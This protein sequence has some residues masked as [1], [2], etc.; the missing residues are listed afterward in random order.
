MQSRYLLILLISFIYISKSN[1]QIYISELVNNEVIFCPNNMTENEIIVASFYIELMNDIKFELEDMVYSEENV[2]QE[3]K[4]KERLK[5]REKT[6][7]KN[8]I[9]AKQLAGFEI[10]R[11]DSIKNLWNDL[12]IFEKSLVEASDLIKS[13][14][15]I[16]FTT[17]TGTFHSD[18][19][20]IEIKKYEEGVERKESFPVEFEVASTQW[21][22]K[23]TDKTCLS[24]N[25][26]DCLVWCLT[27]VSKGYKFKDI[28]GKEY[29][30][31]DCP[32]GLEYDDD[33]SE[34][35]RDI[36]FDEEYAALEFAPLIDNKSQEKL[37][38]IDWKIVECK[39]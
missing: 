39:E 2:I 8:A 21:V 7:L 35:Y 26:D 14:K 33:N 13:G 25:P 10:S 29:K 5:R 19:L 23:K 34:C 31:E 28:T 22:K 17:E 36:I 16:E 15:C 1:S 11:I 3:L 30:Y 27:E 12:L 37:K 18:E 32:D 24:A 38:V 20:K 4:G 6:E 9:A